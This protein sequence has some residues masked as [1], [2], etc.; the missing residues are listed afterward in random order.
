MK[1]SM[2][3]IGAVFFILLFGIAAKSAGWEQERETKP[4]VFVD[5]NHEIRQ[6]LL[7]RTDIM[8]AYFAGEKNLQAAA[9][10]LAEI[11]ED[12]LYREDL[13]GLK[14]YENTDIETVESCDIEVIKVIN[15][16]SCR[17]HAAVKIKWTAAGLDGR[18]VFTEN[19]MAMCK[20]TGKT[21]KL[22]E[23]F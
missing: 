19:Y 23:F 22:V 10:E 21:L 16:G 7:Q 12:V 14:I 15:P 6:L 8:N 18:T 9:A 1:K 4:E 5:E 13:L 17:L 11:E 20:K 2:L 3:V